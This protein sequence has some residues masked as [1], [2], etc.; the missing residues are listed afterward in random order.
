MDGNEILTELLESSKY[1]SKEQAVA[2][3][4]YFTHPETIESLNNCNI[5]KIVRDPSR[6]GEMAEEFMYDNNFSV[7]DI[8][9]WA[10]NLQKNNFKDVQFNHIYPG[11]K[12][13]A[14]YTCLSN[15]VVTPAFLAKLTDTDESIKY[16][17]K[18]RAY[19]IYGYNPDNLEF[20]TPD[21]YLNIQWRDFMPKLENIRQHFERKA[22]RN[23]KNKAILSIK[24][25]GWVFNDFNVVESSMQNIDC[26]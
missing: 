22:E 16:L 11:P 1:G 2:S 6:R 3:L 15:I 10:N 7:Q 8:F 5:F 17:L 26:N 20:T 13:V 14:K 4:T 9:C 25:F 12:S 21:D 24:K 19:E 23:K 18:Y